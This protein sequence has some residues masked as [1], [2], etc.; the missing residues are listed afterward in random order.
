MKIVS[1]SGM[2]M[3]PP[4]SGPEPETIILSR[5][6][7]VDSARAQIATAAQGVMLGA[8]NLLALGEVEIVEKLSYAI[9]LINRVLTQMQKESKP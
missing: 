5:Q 3:K 4:P 8:M 1:L 2:R 7:C 9:E 6:A